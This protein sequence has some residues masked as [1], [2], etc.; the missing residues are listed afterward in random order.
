N[1]TVAANYAVS[2]AANEVV[3]LTA[4]PGA[5]AHAID[6]TSASTTGVTAT[7]ALTTV[8][9][10]PP[11]AYAGTLRVVVVE[12]EGAA[13]ATHRIFSVGV[14]DGSFYTRDVSVSANLMPV[15]SVEVRGR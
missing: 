6:L 9:A 14:A 3:T 13:A 7:A 4:V 10:T 1:L 8:G 5:G 15:F 11:G 2:E 12:V